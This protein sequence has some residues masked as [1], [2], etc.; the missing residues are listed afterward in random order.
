L[1]IDTEY[2][3]HLL[4]IKPLAMKL[5][6]LWRLWYMVHFVRLPT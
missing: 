4:I 5:V 3:S 1:M 2:M 6:E